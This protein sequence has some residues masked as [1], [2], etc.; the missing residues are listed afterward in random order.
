MKEGGKPEPEDLSPGPPYHLG[1]G[2]QFLDFGFRFFHP[3]VAFEVMKGCGVVVGTGLHG[4]GYGYEWRKDD[5]K[6]EG[7]EDEK[8]RRRH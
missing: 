4:K 5:R 7:D 2:T 6:R 1:C 8:S 3:P